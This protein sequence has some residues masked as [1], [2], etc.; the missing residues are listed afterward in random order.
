MS[1]LTIPC[2][3]IETKRVP[4]EASGLF[5]H[6]FLQLYRVVIVWSA[7]LNDMRLVFTCCGGNN[8]IAASVKP[9]L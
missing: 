4:S 3:L 2:R 8:L 7:G 5:V 6:C 9:Y 1:Y